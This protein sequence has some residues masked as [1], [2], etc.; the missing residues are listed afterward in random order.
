MPYYLFDPH[1]D[2][3]LRYYTNRLGWTVQVPPP[4]SMFQSREWAENVLNGIK[5]IWPRLQIVAHPAPND[6]PAPNAPQSQNETVYVGLWP[7]RKANGEY[8]CRIGT[9]EEV[10]TWASAFEQ[11]YMGEL[12]LYTRTTT[13]TPAKRN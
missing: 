7:Y 8:D 12:T 11:V 4:E 6:T 1:P 5:H 13:F 2:S 3:D 10:V 9:K